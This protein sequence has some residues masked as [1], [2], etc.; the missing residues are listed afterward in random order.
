MR[1]VL[2]IALGLVA[3]SAVYYGYQWWSHRDTRAQQP[4]EALAGDADLDKP[5]ADECAMA[6]AAASAVHAAGDDKRWEAGAGVTTM[7]LGDHSK[8][9]NPAD[10]AGITDDE[11][12][13]LNSKAP[14]DWRWCPGMSAFIAGFSWN[15]MG[16]DYGVAQLALGRPAVNKAGDEARMY[17]AFNAPKEEGGA[18]M[19][20]KGP[21]LVTLHKAP[22]GAWQVTARDD[23]KKYY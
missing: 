20:A 8:V 7:S 17:E 14:A 15:A 3:G 19:L 2:P 13:N 18:P 6:R 5:A 16:S 11:A 9:I 22:N 23:L 12:A 10:Y 4:A 1:F 21:W